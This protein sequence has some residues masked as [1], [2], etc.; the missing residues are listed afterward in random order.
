MAVKS[1]HIH[2]WRAEPRVKARLLAEHFSPTST[3]DLMLPYTIL[4]IMS[5]FPKYFAYFVFVCANCL[6]IFKKC[7]LFFFFFIKCYGKFVSHI[8]A[9]QSV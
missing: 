5:F 6:I 9:F 8:I 2:M 4:F 1:W 3:S 7:W